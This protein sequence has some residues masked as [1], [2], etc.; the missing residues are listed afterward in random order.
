[1]VRVPRVG[2]AEREI[3]QLVRKAVPEQEAFLVDM[4]T[5]PDEDCTYALNGRRV[6]WPGFRK[7][8]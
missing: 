1:M 4:K 5:V 3:H 2:W 6:Y 8:L 7:V